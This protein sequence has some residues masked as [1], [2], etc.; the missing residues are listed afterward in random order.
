MRKGC[1]ERCRGCAHRRL[2]AA[3]SEAQKQA[4]LAAKLAPWSSKLAPIQALTGNER[5]SYRDKLCLSTIWHDSDWQFGLF[6]R[7]ELI[8]IPD[9]PVHS[10][11]A[12][13]VI[14][15][16]APALPPGSLFPMRFY[17]Q[18][19]AQVTLVLKTA[20]MP[21]LD[22]LAPLQNK[23]MDSGVE[24]LWLHLHPAAGRRIF[25]RNGWRLLW[26]QALSVNHAQLTY[27]PAAFQQLI[28]ALYD[29]ALDEAETFLAPAACDSVVDLCCG[30]GATL[31]R[32][33]Q[34]RARV[35]GVE[36]GGE[37]VNCACLNAP[38]S[39]VLRGKCSQRI[40]QLNVWLADADH[41]GKR[42]LY[43]NPPRTGIEPEV[44]AWIT[45]VMRPSRIAYLSCSAGTLH[46]D[47]MHLHNAGFCV[48]RITSY[49]FFPQT[50]HVETL[51][52]LT[53]T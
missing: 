25:T 15:L 22:W 35:I 16:L 49:D 5:W 27:G 46:R 12:R 9:C 39:L 28:P 50:H 41:R 48:E 14:N 18:A 8:A 13:A 29:R 4:W 7:Q 34:H 24:G 21:P 6:A 44:I 51:T 2:D 26:G 36:L 32:W 10:Q 47:L 38:S 45:D 31:A 17:I 11:R 20:R 30:I 23:L 52:L 53:Q 43:V 19:G 37:A 42:L 33:T 40:P 1:V 3:A